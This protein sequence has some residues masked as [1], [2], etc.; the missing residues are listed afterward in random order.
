MIDLYKTKRDLQCPHKTFKCNCADIAL[1]NIVRP[2]KEIPI[3][4]P[5][6]KNGKFTLATEH[7][8]HMLTQIGFYWAAL[9]CANLKDKIHIS[10]L[11]R[12]VEGQISYGTLSLRLCLEE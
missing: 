8:K 7:D 1:Q 9:I 3:F 2:Y 11:D 6:R 5:Y 12:Y 10:G 4:Q